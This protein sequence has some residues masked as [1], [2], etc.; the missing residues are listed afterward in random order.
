MVLTAAYLYYVEDQSQEEIARQLSVSRSTISRLLAEARQTGVV[1]IEVAAPP[2]T[3]GL[4]AELSEQLGLER[5]YLAQGVA[6]PDD[7][8][9][10]LAGA[11]GEALLDSELRPGDALLV[12]W[13]RSTWSMSRA[14]LPAIPGVVVVPAL[15]GLNDEKPWVQTNEIA[16]Q[17]ASRLDGSVLLLHAPAVPSE[18]LRASLLSDESIRAALIRW[19]DAAV[20]LV[21]IGAWPQ[22]EPEPPSI[23]S[24]DKQTLQRSVGDVAAR[25]F[26]ADGKPVPYPAEQRLLGISRKQ[27]L[28]VRRRIGVAVGTRKADAIVAAARS[29]LVNVLVTDVVTASAVTARLGS[30]ASKAAK[31]RRTAAATGRR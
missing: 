28:Q 14:D 29:G 2:P 5:V 13:G 31:P 19:D 22:G 18:K 12:S 21:G 4:E 7:P 6:S 30:I 15:G 10:V 24:M 25:L 1:R 11:L 20:A 26:G 27:L 23:L 3:D 16:R 9:P 8:G 17:L